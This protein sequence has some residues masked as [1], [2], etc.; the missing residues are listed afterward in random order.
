MQNVVPSFSSAHLKWAAKPKVVEAVRE[1][2]GAFA[3]STQDPKQ[4]VKVRNVW[5]RLWSDH[6]DSPKA[7]IHYVMGIS[8]LEN[9]KKMLTACK[10]HNVSIVLLGYKACGR[11]QE[12]PPYDYSDWLEVAKECYGEG[13]WYT[14]AIDTALAREEKQK[15]ANEFYANRKSNCYVVGKDGEDWEHPRHIAFMPDIS[16]VLY[17]VTEGIYSCYIDAVEKKYGP[18]SYEVDK[19]K[20]YK[21]KIPILDLN[22]NEFDY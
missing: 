16:P 14:I 7:Y 8:P 1:C 22:Y 21:N 19:L 20:E 2:V 5:D 4:V 11:A 9:L 17:D 13:S 3:L 15:A 10:K 12:T 18:S 6:Y